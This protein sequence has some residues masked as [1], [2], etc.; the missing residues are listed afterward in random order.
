MKVRSALLALAATSLLFVAG[1][2]SDSSDG[3]S[4]S[5]TEATTTTAADGGTTD[6][7][8]TTDGAPS[9]AELS[10]GV[11]EGLDLAADQADCVAGKISGA[12]L[13]KAALEA[14]A[15]ADE[16]SLS[17]EDQ[18]A[19]ATAVGDAC[20]RLLAAPPKRGLADLAVPPPVTGVLSPVTPRQTERLSSPT[21][22]PRR[23]EEHP[24]WTRTPSPG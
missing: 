24:R 3:D 2:G 18:A 23:Q 6:T 9:D 15:A 11:Q 4:A 12:G 13:S 19:V 1:C 21:G 14:I 20:G 7:G 16:E 10:Q 8:A 22:W 5:T 17:D